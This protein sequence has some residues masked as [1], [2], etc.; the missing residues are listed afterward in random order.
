M[1]ESHGTGA[2]FVRRIEEQNG[3]K[4]KERKTSEK[5]FHAYDSHCERSV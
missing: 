5:G 3:D 2:F 1:I 4:K